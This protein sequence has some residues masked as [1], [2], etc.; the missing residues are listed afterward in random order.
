MDFMNEQL[1]EHDDLPKD[2]DIGLDV[3]KD[4]DGDK[5]ACYYIADTTREEVF[6]LSECSIDMLVE[7]R[8]LPIPKKDPGHLSMCLPS[9]PTA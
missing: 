3:S 6:W 8:N 5:L 1:K 9:S 2:F 4:N 7:Q